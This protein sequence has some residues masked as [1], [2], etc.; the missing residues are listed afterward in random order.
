[1][2]GLIFI[3]KLVHCLSDCYR[4]FY[5]YYYY[6]SKAKP[7]RKPPTNEDVI[8]IFDKANLFN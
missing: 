6:Y 1:M 4:C 5:Y 8:T 3:S 7:R 2:I